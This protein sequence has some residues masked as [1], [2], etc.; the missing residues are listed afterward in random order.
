GGLFVA[1]DLIDSTEMYLRT[2]LELEEEGIPALRARLVER[3][4]LSAPSVSEGIAR[5]ANDGLVS[6]NV[7][8][9]VAL[10]T[11]GRTKANHVLR[12]HRLAERLLV[13][14]LGLE[15]EFVHDE[16]CRWEHVISD[17]VEQKLADYLGN[18]TTSPYGNPIPGADQ[19]TQAHGLSAVSDLSDG[20]DVTV[21][22]IAE[23]AQSDEALMAD[24]ERAGVR[25]GVAARVASGPD[26][27]MLVIGNK[28]VLLTEDASRHIYVQPA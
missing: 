22:R 20:D 18:P 1:G 19:A 24:L 8:R 10:T 28:R 2:V 21:E 14:V 23:S 16:A 11:S 27:V 7:D 25:P 12:K 17:R 13:D 3:L 26:G 5:L 15:P 9:T 6:L 4:G